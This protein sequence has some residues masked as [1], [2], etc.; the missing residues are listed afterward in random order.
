[1]ARTALIQIRVDEP[2][3]KEVDTLFT[4]LGFDTPT[5][6]R[7]FLKQAIKRHGLPFE[8]TQLTPNAE[9]LSAIDEVREMKRNPQL[10]KG[11][12]SVEALFEDLNDGE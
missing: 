4:D 9:T 12:N 10:Y 6:I 8:V 2:M 5:A 11:F 7:M 3:K 1:M